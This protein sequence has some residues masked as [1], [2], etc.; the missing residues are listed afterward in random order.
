M[1]LALLRSEDFLAAHL[2]ATEAGFQFDAF[3]EFGYLSDYYTVP[4]SETYNEPKRFQQKVAEDV[5][6][7]NGYLAN[8]VCRIGYAIVFEDRDSEFPSTFVTEAEAQQGCRVRFIR[9]C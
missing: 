8:G 1:D 9:G 4:G 7:I 3:L 6:K 2:P 5:R